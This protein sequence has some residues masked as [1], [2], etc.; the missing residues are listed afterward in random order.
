MEIISEKINVTGNINDN[1][2]AFLNYKNKHFKIFEKEYENQFN[3]CTDE[4]VEEKEKCINEKL[5]Q[6][7]I[8]E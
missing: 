5:S 7:P 4:D 2:E 8:H 3:V 6:L 1:I